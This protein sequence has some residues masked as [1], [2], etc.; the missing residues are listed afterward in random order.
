MSSQS[1]ISS[2]NTSVFGSLSEPFFLPAEEIGDATANRSTTSSVT[3]G[4]IF[5]GSLSSN[6]EDWIEV[7]LEAGET[8]V[9]TAW[10]TGGV[11]DGLWDPVL[12]VYYDA[13]A[14]SIA[15]NDDAASDT[16]FSAV[17]FTAE[18][19][20]SY[21]IGIEGYDGEAGDYRVQAATSVFTPEQAATFLSEYAWGV[22]TPIAHDERSGNTMSVNITGLTAEGQQLAL[23]ALE[24]WENVT[25][26]A[27]TTTSSSSADIVFDDNQSGA[28]AGP[29]SYFLE[30]GEII[31]A[32]VNISDDWL[33]LYGTTID[34]YSFL[35]YIHEIGHALGLGHAGFYD[36]FASYPF[37]ALYEN[38]SYQMTV[39]SYF[40]IADNRYI[41][42]SDSQ[43]VTAMIADIIAIQ[44]LYG[45]NVDYEEGDTVW[46][47][48]STVGGYMGDIMGYIFD[49][50]DVS[51]DMISGETVLAATIYDT[52]GIDLINLSSS[53]YDGILD[54]TSGGV[55]DVNGFVGNIVIA[56]D[57]VIENA[58]AG[59]GDDTIIGNTA[60]NILRGGSGGDVLV[61]G[62]GSDTADY[63]GYTGTM[64]VGAH[65]L[66]LQY[67]TLNTGDGAG[68]TYNSIENITGSES[69]ELL[70]GDTGNN[71]LDGA[72]NVDFIAGRQG[73]DT[74][75]GGQANDVLV[76]GAGADHL[77]GGA[78]MDQARYSYSLTAVVID[79]EDVSL[80][81]GEAAGDTY[82]SIENIAGSTFSDLL[83]GDAQDNLLIGDGNHDELYGRDGDDTLN[84]GGGVDYLEGGAGDD[85]LW[86]GYGPDTFVFTEGH[87]TIE[88]YFDFGFHDQIVID[89]SLTNG[90]LTAA[91][92]V[93][94]YATV[95]GNDILFDF[96]GDSLL[97][98]DFNDLTVITNNIAIV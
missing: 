91:D 6:D 44:S 26:L 38:D 54:L 49:G 9:F 11:Y 74:L 94:T 22:P 68:D 89:Q 82:V 42:G 51:S 97:V 59:S 16:H 57:T 76:G 70:R 79:M 35:T 92:V 90:A 98:T 25:G 48:G 1:L 45:T 50:E 12:T 72:G 8:Y 2:K 84:G 69:R 30:T 28:F 61:G 21:Y 17:S 47:E 34:S 19:S 39:M 20:G 4:D 46:G 40:S 53:T 55:S 67:S 86:G 36:G 24:A 37:N 56:R 10:G 41:D 18:V 85:T 29:S 33:D 81:T 75:Y 93:S 52:G 87:D 88:D 32:T 62:S 78:D 13:G 14:D 60:D 83:Y 65:V 77:D 3:I 31:Q 5:D 95:V 23:W 80:N 71:I 58:W 7:E 15:Y 63:T 64:R 73:D 27:F 43:P 96:G 66:D